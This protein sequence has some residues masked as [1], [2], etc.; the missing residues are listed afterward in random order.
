MLNV[1]CYLVLGAALGAIF[2]PPLGAI[3][4]AMLLI[5]LFLYRG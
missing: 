4:G 1:I 3:C 5:I 2:F